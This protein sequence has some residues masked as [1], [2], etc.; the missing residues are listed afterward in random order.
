MQLRSIDLFGWARLSNQFSQLTGK[1]SSEIIEII[2]ISSMRI[3]SVGLNRDVNR[4]LIK[5]ALMSSS[6]RTILAFLLPNN[7]ENAPV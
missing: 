3:R 1:K 6:G 7:R 2:E 4:N 5:I